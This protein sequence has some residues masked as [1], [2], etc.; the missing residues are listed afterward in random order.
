MSK[1]NQEPTIL[2]ETKR[3]VERKYA[4]DNNTIRKTRIEEHKERERIRKEKQAEKKLLKL[5]KLVNLKILFFFFYF[6]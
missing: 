6:F 1:I 5:N 2:Q 3:R 4:D